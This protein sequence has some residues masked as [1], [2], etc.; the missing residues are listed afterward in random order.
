TK[1]SSIKP[2]EQTPKD[3][4]AAVDAA[5]AQQKQTNEQF[6][7]FVKDGDAKFAAKRWSEALTAFQSALTLKAD[8]AGVAAKIANCETEINKEAA[9]ESQFNQHV[10]DGDRLFAQQSW[11]EAKTAYQAALQIKSDKALTDKIKEIDDQL[12]QEA[13]LEKQYQTL[14]TQ[15]DNQLKIKNYI[16][17]QVAYEAA[18]QLKPDEPLPKER[19]AEIASILKDQQEMLEKSYIDAITA[20]D[21]FLRNNDFVNAK[22]EYTKASSIKPK[23]QTPKDKLAAVDAAIAQQKQTNEQFLAFVK[24]GDAKFAAKRWSEALTAFQSA[25]TLKANDAGVAAK[26]AN[27]EAEINKAAAL[28]SQ[29]NQH[30]ADGD[31]LFAQQSWNEA[32][33]AYQAALQIKS[34]K[35]LTDKIKEIDDQLLQEANLEKQYQTLITQADNQLKIKNYIDAQVAYEA[36]LQ[37]KPDETLPKERLAEI[38]SILQDQQEMLEKSYIDAITA[39]DNFLRNNDFVNAKAEYTK[40]SSIKPKE[41]TPK[42]KLAAVDAAIAQQKQTNEQFLAFV[43]DGDAKFAAKRWSEALTAFQSA[44]TL[45]A[46]DVG[47]AAKIANCETEINK[48]AALESQFNQHVADGDRLFAQ[49]S[50]NEAKTAYQAALQIK[51]DKALTDKIK[52]ID[53]QLLQEANLEKQYQTLMLTAT[54]QTEAKQWTAAI[55]SYNKVLT[56]K[57]ADPTA[58]EKLTYVTEQ[59]RNEQAIEAQYQEWIAKGDEAFQND[60][61]DEATTA[62]QKALT[63]K[64]E[65][66]YPTQKIAEIVVKKQAHAQRLE[67]YNQLIT[68]TQTAIQQKNWTKAKTDCQQALQIFPEEQAPKDLM[69]TIETALAEIEATRQLYNKTI[70]AASVA[71]TQNNREE[72]LLQYEKAAL[73]LPEEMLP[74]TKIQEINAAIAAE[75]NQEIERQYAALMGEANTLITNK[76]YELAVDKLE[77]ALQV[78]QGDVTAQNKLNEVKATIQRLAQLETDYATALQ[79][80][81][82]HYNRKEYESALT[83]YEKALALKP[84]EPYLQEQINKTKYNINYSPEKRQSL[85][86]DFVNKGIE[87][88]NNNDF[89]AA[90]ISFASATSWYPE[91]TNEAQTAL[92]TMFDKLNNGKVKSILNNKTTIA[93]NTTFNIKTFVGTNDLDEKAFIILKISGK[94]EKD[95]NV[96]IRYGRYSITLGNNILQVIANAS[97]GYYCV[98][99]KGTEND[100][101]WMTIMPENSDITIDEVILVSPK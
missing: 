58:T 73:L 32:K 94:S 49:Q 70:A 29:F 54:T 40:A 12:L 8:D 101:N 37:L 78:K 84:D 21:N 81:D 47:V 80:G 41:Q 50:W 76:S 2:K 38:A 83:F 9:L 85:A 43:K 91:N 51:S 90:S 18:L 71:L 61:L 100:I 56:I 44:L 60:R 17:A 39:G 31:R 35:A 67:S 99:M 10:A 28:E 14:I 25:L 3:K 69:K 77:A 89:A 53:D 92:T 87:S 36:A 22:A 15:A 13:N 30:V 62:F 7:A 68:S 5:I 26:I 57:P 11:N 59:L 52:E 46:D 48:A 34:D 64:A 66:A 20:G 27:C 93:A 65:A 24:D 86:K 88:M 72:A 95:F 55:E 63:F 45:K 1:A 42:D 6:L 75:K 98:L 79:E 19:L 74:K 23:E 97:V 82:T 96:F 16:D 33:T 4:L